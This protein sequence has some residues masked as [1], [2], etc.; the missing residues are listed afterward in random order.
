MADNDQILQCPA[1]QKTMKKIF[2]PEQ[3]INLDVCLDGCGGI[4]FDNREFKYFDEQHENT[5]AL[6]K[7]LE[8]KTF[9]Q[10]DE[11]LTRKCPVCGTNMVK[12]HSSVRKEIQIDECYFCGGKFLDNGELIKIRAEY[13]TE[14][15][16]SA[17]FLSTV[18]KTIGNIEETDIDDSGRRF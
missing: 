14:A 3:G 7:V 18:C 16:R 13:K 11:S 12:N 10:V 2:M 1:C 8:G 15:D 6:L 4:Y 17:D 5:D 9:E